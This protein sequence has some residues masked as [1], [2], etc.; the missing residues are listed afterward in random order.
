MTII[1][2]Q[3]EIP[4]VKR[5]FGLSFAI[6]GLVLFITILSVMP[7]IFIVIGLGLNVAEGSEIDL[8]SKTYRTIHSLFGIKI[9]KWNPIPDFEYVSVFKTNDKKRSV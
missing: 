5:F 1:S 9:G 2:Y 8:S 4:F 3:K 6:L 7:I